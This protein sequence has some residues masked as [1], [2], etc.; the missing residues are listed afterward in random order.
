MAEIFRPLVEQVES[1]IEQERAVKVLEI[2]SGDSFYGAVIA[3]TQYKCG[4][5]NAK[6]DRLF[7]SPPSDSIPTNIYEKTFFYNSEADLESLDIYDCIVVTQLFDSLN[8]D[9]AKKIID[10][11]QTKVIK[12]ILVITPEYNSTHER[13]YHPLSLLGIDFAYSLHQINAQKWQLYQIFTKPRYSPMALDNIP[14]QSLLL[15]G[16]KIA[17]ILPHANLTGG[18]KALLQ[19]AKNLTAHGHIVKL[20]W[21]NA[22]HSMP[23]WSI[24]SKNDYAE[25]IAI[26]KGANPLDIIKD[27]DVIILGWMMQSYEFFASKIPVVMWE[28]GSEW[29]FGDYHHP[30]T[31]GFYWRHHMHTSLRM[32]VNIVSVSHVTQTVLEKVFNRKSHIFPCGIDIDF[33]KPS[34]KNEEDV[35]VIFLVGNASL[36]FK[37]FGFAFDVLE[38]LWNQGAR[39]KVKWASQVAVQHGKISFPLEVIVHPSQDELVKLYGS[40]DIY[41]STSLYEA[42]SLPPLEAMACKTA[43]VA[44]D[45]GGIHSYGKN[46]ENCI[47]FS[48]GDLGTA[49]SSL[50]L[51]IDDENERLRFAEKGRQTALENS[52]DKTICHL[53]KYLSDLLIYKNKTQIANRLPE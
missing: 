32:P 52:C 12:Q 37:G 46:G 17:F 24:L 13:V 6:I 47:I 49:V 38:T 41:F 4:I 1:Y 25:Q 18:M 28:Q 7:L 2:G 3:D 50:K 48:Q 44:A 9:E 14:K 34:P 42:Y 39:F 36:A 23:S 20:Y 15:K 10:I 31:H 11:L 22:E 30:I 26:P 27:V 19:Q 5:A 21:R 43:V 8:I 33:Y 29:L 40:S 35:P 45:N 53:E 16:M 51:L